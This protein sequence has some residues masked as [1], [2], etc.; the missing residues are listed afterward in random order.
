MT[1]TQVN[2]NLM[3]FFETLTLIFA[4][5]K[6]LGCITWSWWWVFAPILVHVVLFVVVLI[7][8]C[9]VAALAA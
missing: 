9:V 1:K 4:I 3:G 2:F 7:I 5:A 8:V 6:I